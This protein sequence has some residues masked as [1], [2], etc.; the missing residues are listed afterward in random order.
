MEDLSSLVA[1]ERDVSA[2]LCIGCALLHHDYREILG[3]C[4]IEEYCYE[5]AMPE[6]W[7]DGRRYR[8]C[9]GVKARG[10]VCRE[11]NLR[12]PGMYVPVRDGSVSP[13]AC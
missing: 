5:K 10:A 3:P 8:L 7:I 2:G 6:A 12:G 4:T 11:C 1:P 13:P 9:S